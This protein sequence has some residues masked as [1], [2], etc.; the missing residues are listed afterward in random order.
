[1][2]VFVPFSKRDDTRRVVCGIATSSALDAH[3]QRITTEAIKGAIAK[4]MEFGNIR[5]MHQPSAIGKVQKHE[6]DPEDRLYIE[7]KIVDPL[8]WEKV[9]KGI[10]TGFSVGGWR[11]DES[12]GDVIKS[13]VLDEISL[14]DRPANP[15]AYFQIMKAFALGRDSLSDSEMAIS[16]LQG[17]E[18]LYARESSE[19]KRDEAQ[20]GIIN[21]VGLLL[22]QFIQSELNESPAG[23]GS[24]IEGAGMENEKTGGGGEDENAVTIEKLQKQVEALAAE[25][26]AIAKR[27]ADGAKIE[28]LQ[29]RIAELEAEKTVLQKSAD[30]R[31]PAP[32][33]GVANAAA[34]A[35]VVEKSADA[36]GAYGGVAN[37]AIPMFESPE[38]RFARL[39][40][41]DNQ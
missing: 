27:N 38:Q 11:T 7:A 26:V 39:N 16:I 24:V 14:V 30:A 12:K 6:F 33:R 25:N 40:K 36:V 37:G 8:A 23:E 10:Y 3:G 13:M 2:K 28:E 21:Q 5:E 18:C 15:E 20:L 19:E 34:A 35:G 9:E 41:S 31:T 29:K 22:S 4:Y 32:I 17:V 1:M